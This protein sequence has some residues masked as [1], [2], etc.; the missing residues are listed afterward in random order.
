M[1]L[2]ASAEPGTTLLLHPIQTV[3]S[4]E[5]A[6]FKKS[7][8]S[9]DWYLGDLGGQAITDALLRPPVLICFALCLKN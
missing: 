7:F 5:A 9:I 8:K 6:I 1:R 2:A 4:S 3:I